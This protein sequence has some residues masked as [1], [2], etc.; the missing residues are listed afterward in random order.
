MNILL[1]LFFI[2]AGGFCI[3]GAVCNWE[4]FMNSRKARGMV[5]ILGR[6]GARG[7]Y[8]ILGSVIVIMGLLFAVGVIP[9]GNP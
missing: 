9:M 7:F 5:A 3:T 2:A 4:F 6:N 8:V 1:G